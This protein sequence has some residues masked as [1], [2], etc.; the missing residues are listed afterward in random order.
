M[1]ILLA[2]AMLAA[3]LINAH[4]WFADEKC[5]SARAAHGVFASTNPACAL[6][7]LKGGG[8][9]V[10]IAEEQK[11]IYKVV[12][13]D[14]YLKHVGEYVEV[15][16]AADDGHNLTIDSLKTIEKVGPSCGMRPKT[17]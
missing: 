2:T 10:F 14:E 5:A 16:G 7:C 3:T 4:G 12:K 13:T 11:A 6:K 9:L 1:N 15:V 17:H 8:N